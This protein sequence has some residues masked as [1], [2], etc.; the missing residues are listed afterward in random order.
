MAS[1]AI[2]YSIWHAQL[3]I[4]ELKKEK[5]KE[6]KR[7]RILEKKSHQTCDEDHKYSEKVISL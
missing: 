5:T 7:K 3:A 4:C 6:N 2:L 1:S